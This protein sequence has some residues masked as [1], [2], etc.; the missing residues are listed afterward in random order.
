MAGT[1]LQTSLGTNIVYTDKEVTSIG[2]NYVVAASSAS[3]AL[4]APLVDIAGNSIALAAG[5]HIL[6]KTDATLQA[7][8]NTL[9]LNGGAAKSIFN[10]GATR[11]LKTT[12][13]VG[14]IA[15]LIYDGTNWIMMNSTY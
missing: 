6:L 4:T 13:A 5:L 12:T 9:A 11:N 2:P 8:A 1:S 14:F 10:N 7:G 15:D 3:N